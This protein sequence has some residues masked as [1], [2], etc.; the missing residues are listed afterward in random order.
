MQRNGDGSW[1]DENSNDGF[2]DVRRHFDGFEEKSRADD[3][4]SSQPNS[5]VIQTDVFLRN[6]V[7]DGNDVYRAAAA[8]V[9][10]AIDIRS[11]HEAVA[12]G[13]PRLHI[14]SSEN[15]YVPLPHQM[16]PRK[17]SQPLRKEQIGCMDSL[18]AGMD[19][20]PGAH[21]IQQETHQLPKTRNISMPMDDSADKESPIPLLPPCFS[22]NTS[23]I[24]KSSPQEILDGVAAFLTTQVDAEFQ[25][26]KRAYKCSG[27][28]FWEEKLCQFMVSL[29]KTPPEHNHPNCILI[30]FQRRRGDA[31]AYQN[32]YRATVDALKERDLVHFNGH[33]DC[34]D[35][36]QLPTQ[37]PALRMP[38]PLPEDLDWSDDESESDL[39]DECQLAPGPPGVGLEMPGSDPIG[40]DCGYLDFSRDRT[41]C[42]NLVRMCRSIYLEPRR[43]ATSVLA[44]GS[45]TKSNAV[46]LAK[47]P[48]IMGTLINMLKECADLQ[49]TRNTALVLANIFK[50]ATEVRETA[51]KHTMFKV[52]TSAFTQWSGADDPKRQSKIVSCQIG[53]AIEILSQT[54]RSTTQSF[55]PDL[56]SIDHLKRI[57]LKSPIPQAVVLANRVLERIGAC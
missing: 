33:P 30:E 1:S 54:D 42:N 21:S 19:A 49:V 25:I 12:I 24:S 27:K 38:L 22:R 37:L 43:E 50:F 56:S 35:P 36:T 17:K 4:S 5:N 10:R 31:F 20:P 40:P 44:R 18:P 53:E 7:Y 6:E 13:L 2:E 45:R 39:D 47:V 29:F 48:Q 23:V 26:K 46:L 51:L 15:A 55:M 34:P 14:G 41:L 32:I 11:P 3:V 8:P 9:Y 16:Q 28:F 57:G 52:M